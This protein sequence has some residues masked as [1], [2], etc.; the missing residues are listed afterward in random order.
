VKIII[1]Y[2][3]LNRFKGCPTLGQNRQFQ[4]FKEPTYIYPVVPAQAATMLKQAGHQVIWLDCIAAEISLEQFL[5][6]LKAERPDV[7]AIET[8]TPAVKQHWEIIDEIKGA[9]RGF[10]KVV[11]FGDHVTAL[12]EE[13]C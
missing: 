6:T 7:I 9:L 3:P 5:K 4:Y 11:F 8:K 2:P 10:P 13:S 1:A 12:A